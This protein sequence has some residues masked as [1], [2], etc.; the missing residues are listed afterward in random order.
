M[1]KTKLVSVLS[2][3]LFLCVPNFLFESNVIFGQ[4]GYY[5]TG[6]TDNIENNLIR[7]VEYLTSLKLNGRRAG[8]EGERLAAE[9]IYNELRNGGLEM[10]CDKNGQQFSILSGADSIHSANVVG[11]VEGYDPILKNEY[12]VVG[13]NYDGMG[14]SVLTVNG[15]PTT[16]IFSGAD[17]NASGVACLLELA[18]KVSFSSFL[19]RR[20]IVF[21]AFGAKEEGM[22]GSWFFLNK[23]FGQRDDISMMVDISRVGRSDISSRFTYYTGAPNKDIINSVNRTSN[24]L[25]FMDPILGS[26][27]VP[28][29]DYLAFYEQNIPVALFTNGTHP[30]HYTVRDVAQN[31]DYGAM[32]GVCEYLF[33][34]I[35]DIASLD[36]KVER[37]QQ[38]QK[39]GD[40]VIYSP[41]DVEKPAE[42]F[43]GDERTFLEKWVYLYLKY[44]EEAM[45]MGTQGVVTVEFVV[46]TEGYV[47]DV[48]VVKG[49]DEELDKEAVRVVSASPKWKP[50][51]NR[52]EKVRVK[53][54]IPIE[55]RLKKRK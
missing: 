40:V 3:V 25:S 37:T 24:R 7:H 41:Y 26:G 2:L 17:A 32:E 20:S 8:S 48:K 28:T 27:R 50:A 5:P 54:T 23:S 36:E 22:A 6:H 13:A 38:T 35:S 1:I 15:H 31:L 52:G 33:T 4:G 42:F 16:Q 34:F 43:R 9:Y 55:F 49:I 46:D 19:F 18:K 12:I 44:P 47:S 51:T 39:E 30:D 11:I 14:S 10:L 29:S 45:I 21:V 53:Y